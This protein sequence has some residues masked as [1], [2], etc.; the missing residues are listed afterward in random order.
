M[1]I[2][3]VL[4]L[5]GTLG[6]AGSQWEHYKKECQKSGGK[7]Y[8]I[9]NDRFECK[10]HKQAKYMKNQKIIQKKEMKDPG[11]DKGISAMITATF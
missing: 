6:M 7:A 1:K 3:L 9:K 11:D 5:I 8:K 10:I 4:F 2:I